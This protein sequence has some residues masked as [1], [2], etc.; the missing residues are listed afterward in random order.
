MP[1]LS[2]VQSTNN[3]KFG[4]CEALIKIGSWELAKTI[5]SSIPPFS[6]VSQKSI[7]QC[8]CRLI[9][10]VIEPLYYQYVLLQFIEQFSAVIWLYLLFQLHASCTVP[11]AVCLV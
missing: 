4:L 2:L 10:F 5:M 11:G 8:L 3:Q 9:H 7:A 6:A 1:H